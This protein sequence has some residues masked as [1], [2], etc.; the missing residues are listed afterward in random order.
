[1][2]FNN[3]FL[4]DKKIIGGMIMEDSTLLWKI[5]EFLFS[6]GGRVFLGVIYLIK[7]IVLGLAASWIATDKKKQI[8]WF[9]LGLF[10]GSISLLVLMIISYDWNLEKKNEIWI[11]EKCET[12]N[13]GNVCKNCGASKSKI[14]V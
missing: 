3:T 6:E 9:V 10:F 11:C 4:K 14:I 13:T 2:S 1:M 8:L 7:A 12:E 5:E